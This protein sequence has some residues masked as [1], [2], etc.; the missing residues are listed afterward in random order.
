MI[1]NQKPESIWILAPSVFLVKLGVP[2][3]YLLY[4][5]G[6]VADSYLRL[7]INAQQWF[8]RYEYSDFWPSNMSPPLEIGGTYSS[9]NKNWRRNNYNFKW[10][11]PH[12]FHRGRPVFGLNKEWT[13]STFCDPTTSTPYCYPYCLSTCPKPASSP[14]V[15]LAWARLVLGLGGLLLVASKKPMKHVT[16]LPNPSALASPRI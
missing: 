13:L 5:S 14:F 8:W 3:L 1:E 9:S 16:A 15:G 10:W 12:A 7:N 2:S 11:Y 6:H 4:I